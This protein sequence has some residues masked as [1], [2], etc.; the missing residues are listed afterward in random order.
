ML[1]SRCSHPLSPRADRCLRCFAL[2]PTNRSDAPAVPWHESAPSLPVTASIASDPPVAPVAVSFADEPVAVVAEVD[3]EMEEPVTEPEPA[4]PPVSPAPPPRPRTPSRPSR[5]ARLAGWGLD[6]A[7]V[8]GIAAGNVYV[9]GRMCRT[10]Y[11]LDFVREAAPLLLALVAVVALAYSFVFVALSG[12]TPGM[13]LTGQRLRTL[14]GDDPTPAE[15]LG[16]AALSL[17]SAALGLFGFVLALFDA[18]GQTLHDKLS[19]CVVR[20]D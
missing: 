7:L 11:W 15:A 1:C 9:A 4:A 18:R 20:I 2:N 12:R 16:R 5:G 10:A 19:R 17:P 8:C 3:V 6:A 13:A 14:H